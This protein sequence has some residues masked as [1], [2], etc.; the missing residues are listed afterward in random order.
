MIIGTFS[1][2]HPIIIPIYAQHRLWTWLPTPNNVDQ[3]SLT[4]PTRYS[5]CP[6]CSCRHLQHA[7]IRGYCRWRVSDFWLL[8][9]ARACNHL[10]CWCWYG[11]IL[12]IVILRTACSHYNGALDYNGALVTSPNA[13]LV[14]AFLEGRFHC[15]QEAICSFLV[16]A[17]PSMR[18][19]VT[20]IQLSLALTPFRW[21]WRFGVVLAPVVL[22]SDFKT[23][24]QAEVLPFSEYNYSLIRPI[25]AGRLTLLTWEALLM[26][27]WARR[28]MLQ[29]SRNH[30]LSH[31]SK[32][33]SYCH[34]F[35]L[36]PPPH[37]TSAIL[38]NNPSNPC[39][40]NYSRKHLEDILA[41]AK[42]AQLPVGRR[43]ICTYV[44]WIIIR[45]QIS[46]YFMTWRLKCS[47]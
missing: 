20:R 11:H 36:P 17:S 33:G 7:W 43:G 40:S 26:T 3:V 42:E 23:Y 2:I 10:H 29:L 14:F 30:Y 28:T 5:R 12:L 46:F 39:G 1:H 35:L 21:D 19:T 41:I 34:A 47:A 25:R 6:Y 31:I 37:Q 45:D 8:I 13:K 32:R 9:R 15:I 16:P 22:L 18:H 38:V 4:I 44:L 24:Q 27:R